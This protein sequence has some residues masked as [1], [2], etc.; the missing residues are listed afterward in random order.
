MIQILKM[1]EAFCRGSFENCC[2]WG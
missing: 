2:S 1:S